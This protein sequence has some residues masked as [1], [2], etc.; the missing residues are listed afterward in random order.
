MQQ[1]AARDA[2][3][4]T[5]GL[6][7]PPS[8]EQQIGQ[9]RQTSLAHWG[10]RS[11]KELEESNPSRKLKKHAAW[12]RQTVHHMLDSGEQQAEEQPS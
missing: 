1:Q 8:S 12:T 7:T 2:S 11:R 3:I 4:R 10:L 6:A 5:Q 9:A